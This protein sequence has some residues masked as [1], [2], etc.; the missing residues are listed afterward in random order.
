MINVS[1]EFQTAVTAPSRQTTARV[2]FDISD[3]TAADDATETVTSEAEISRKDQL[4]NQVRDRPAYATF[5]PDYWRLDG[6]FVLPPKVTEPGFEVGWYSNAFSGAGGAFSPAQV[7][8]FAF[9]GPHSSIGL[10]VT[11]DA[12]ADEYAADFD[13]VV[14]DALGGVIKSFTVRGNTGSRYVIDHEQL[15]DYRQ[16]TITL[17]SWS[18]PNRRAKVTEVSFGV[19]REYGD[20]QLIK[21]NLIEEIDTTSATVPANELKFVIDNSS[22]EF[23]ILNPGGSYA[24]LQERQAVVIEIGVEVS[25][26]IFEFVNMGL[27]FLS[28]WQSDEGSLTTTFTA[29]N[30]IDFIPPVEVENLVSTSTNLHAM[31]LEIINTLGIEKYNLDP[32]LASIT[33]QGMYRKQK[34][35][36]LLQNIAVA[37]QC[38]M[39]VDRDDFLNIIRLASGTPVDT[40]DFD[41][42]YSEPQIKLDKLVNRAEVNY[43]SGAETVAGTYVL[44]GQHDG[45]ATL[46]VENTLIN[47]AAHAQSVA[48]WIISEAN[49]RALY[50]V[51]WRQNPAL[52]CTDTVTIE[53][54]YGVNKSSMIT[55]QEFEYAGYLS[56]KTKS[57]GAI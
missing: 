57:K 38:A 7:L 52:E 30:R 53:D 41:N 15:T 20:D 19:V 36:Q 43:Y 13:I 55:T 51:N 5:E 40:I 31:A 42:I 29:R 33:T 24:F 37:G 45:G 26:N 2:T 39:F 35:R 10:T 47:T 14:Y 6:S 18:K 48:E 28:D 49:K 1:P 21:V 4:T 11:F 27:Y 46:K 16:I 17:L 32:V 56:G 8:D 25:P 34:Y 23:N 9:S 50:D 22:R 12:A 44:T 3:V 54:V